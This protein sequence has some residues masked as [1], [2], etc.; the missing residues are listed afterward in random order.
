[1]LD[2]LNNQTRPQDYSAKITGAANFA[3]TQRLQ[4]ISNLSAEGKLST[5]PGGNFK[6]LAGIQSATN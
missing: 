2:K 6:S 1:M 4:Q 5:V 3:T